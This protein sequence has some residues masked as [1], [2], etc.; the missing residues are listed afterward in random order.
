MSV[1]D[2]LSSRSSKYTVLISDLHLAK[3][4]VKFIDDGAVNVKVFADVRF[5]KNWLSGVSCFAKIGM[6]MMTC[7]I[8][9]MKAM[10]GRKM[11]VKFRKWCYL[12]ICISKLI[13]KN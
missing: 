2:G 3:I 12:L 7:L 13:I 1:V 11:L 4:C 8:V 5:W 6:S 10:S 9:L